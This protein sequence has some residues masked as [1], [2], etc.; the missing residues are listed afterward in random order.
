MWSIGLIEG[1]VA[2]AMPEAC[3]VPCAVVQAQDAMIKKK[4]MF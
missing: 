2:A 4:R 3:E 1:N